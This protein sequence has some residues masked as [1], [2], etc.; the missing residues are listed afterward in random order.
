MTF[1]IFARHDT[2]GHSQ[3]NTLHGLMRYLRERVDVSR[4][5]HVVGLEGHKHQYAHHNEENADRGYM[6]TAIR[7][8]GYKMPADD[9]ARN[10]NLSS[11][12]YGAATVLT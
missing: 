1:P 5:V 6:L 7:G 8:K 12:M 10:L 11:Q 3:Y 2:P 4:G 9:H